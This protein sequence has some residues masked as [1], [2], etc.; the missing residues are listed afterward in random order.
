MCKCC[1]ETRA[2]LLRAAG[3]T[4]TTRGRCIATMQFPRRSG[5]DEFAECELHCCMPNSRWPCAQH[6][7]C[8]QG[9]RSGAD[10]HSCVQRGA[11]YLPLLQAICRPVP[12]CF[13]AVRGLQ[14]RQVAAA[15]V[16]GRHQLQ[17]KV[18]AVRLVH[19]HPWRGQERRDATLV[20][21][22]LRCK[23]GFGK[24]SRPHM[25]CATGAPDLSDKD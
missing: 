17:E 4:T 10:M 8:A 12:V 19:K 24:V 6:C 25:R 21:G 11:A 7:A 22:I 18:R 23:C 14:R 1:V 20:R 3:R 16:V 9:P 2:N 15:H 5:D 13:Q